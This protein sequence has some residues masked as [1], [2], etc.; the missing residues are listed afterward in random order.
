[1]LGLFLAMLKELGREGNEAYKV[2]W[3]QS[4]DASARLAVRD[5]LDP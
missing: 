3:K 4:L 1:M 2:K 5:A